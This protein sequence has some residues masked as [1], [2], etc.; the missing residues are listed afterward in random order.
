MTEDKIVGRSRNSMPRQQT[1]SKKVIS[2]QKQPSSTALSNSLSSQTKP[3]LGQT[4][5]EGFAFGVGNSI[6]H[7]FIQSVFSS[8]KIPSSSNST[9]TTLIESKPTSFDSINSIGAYSTQD[10][11]GQLEY[12]QCMKEG[13]NEEVCKQ[14]MI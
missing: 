6:A 12:L 13:G 1:S 8:T 5:K 10:L 4:L 3:S 2:I 11:S 7:S 14:Y 9:T